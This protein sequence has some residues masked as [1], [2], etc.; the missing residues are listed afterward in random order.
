MKLKQ[1]ILGLILS[2]ISFIGKSQCTASYSVIS[3][4]NGAV[5][6]SNTSVTSNPNCYYYW[7]WGDGTI[8]FSIGTSQTETH[9]YANGIYSVQLILNDTLG[10]CTSSVVTTVTVNTAPCNTIINDILLGQQQNGYMT[11]YPIGSNFGNMA[12]YSWN[13]SD[14]A[15][16]SG[17]NTSHTFT[18]S[19]MYTTTL[20]VSDQLGIC[21]YT[22]QKTFSVTVAPCALTP[23][24]TYSV[25]NNGLVTFQ[26]TSTGTT[27]N[28]S[29]HWNFG[30]FTGTYGS[31]V[32]HTYLNSGNYSVNLNVHDSVNFT[33]INSTNQ[34]INIPVCV[35]HLSFYL[36]KDST[37]LPNIVW[38][39]YPTYSQNTSS[40]M[41]DWGDGTTTNGIM[42]PSHTYSTTGTFNICVSS[43]VSCGQT[44]SYCLNST[45][46]KSSDSNLVLGPATINVI[47]TAT[48]IQEQNIIS[49]LKVYPNPIADELTIEATTK[50]GSNL[51]YNLIDALGKIVLQ[52]NI[53]NSKATINTS[54]LEKG[55]YSL[56]ISNE[57]GSSLKTIKL[58]K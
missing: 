57:K 51:N 15:T 3:S 9:N 37:Q 49:D 26:S 41:W 2:L 38:N 17:F 52:G 21:N 28:T 29:Y 7:H 6:F 58:V 35:N 1:I 56:R 55:F 20:T 53:E 11:F 27:S 48:T 31:S 33:C 14:G 4:I 24:F 22:F 5:T 25:G 42:Y 45:I 40:V 34:L 36:R 12:S 39:T 46:F 10:I 54:A 30:D 16:S 32:S 44:N 18:N 13:F 50:D 19:G 8:D 23:S 47:Q 43:T